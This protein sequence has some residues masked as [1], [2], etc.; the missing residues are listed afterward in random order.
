MQRLVVDAS[1]V[2]KRFVNEENS[3]KAVRI[4]N[5]YIDGEI[6]VMAPDI[7]IFEVLNALYYKRIFSEDELVEISEALD[8]YS[9]D[10]YPIEG[11]YSRKTVEVT[12]K[13]DITIYDAA[14]VTLAMIKNAI[15]ISADEDLIKKLRENYSNHV[16]SLRD[17]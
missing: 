11:E 15:M 4:R 9:F 7:I 8:A 14:Y 17:V 13:N 16:K 3:D 6:S 2:A 5:K 10:L 12:F 1:V